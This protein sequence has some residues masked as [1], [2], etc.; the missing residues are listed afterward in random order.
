MHKYTHARHTHTHTHT[1]VE[2]MVRWRRYDGDEIKLKLLSSLFYQ[3]LISF[4]PSSL[5]QRAIA[6]IASA[7]HRPT[8]EQGDEAMVQCDPIGHY[9]SF[10]FWV[11][12]NRLAH[13]LKPSIFNYRRMLKALI[14]TEVLTRIHV[15]VRNVNQSL[16]N[17]IF[18]D[19]ELHE[20]HVYKKTSTEGI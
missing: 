12:T 17:G 11:P 13:C 10:T 14:T 7:H 4:A 2:A 20:I 6:I 15:T 8:H 9:S 16:F 5:H 1:H 19:T 3:R 18:N